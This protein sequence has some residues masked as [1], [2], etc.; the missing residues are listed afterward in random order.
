MIV[1]YCIVSEIRPEGLP[2]GL[3]GGGGG[4]GRDEEKGKLQNECSTFGLSN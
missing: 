1:A 3:R 4:V 2:D